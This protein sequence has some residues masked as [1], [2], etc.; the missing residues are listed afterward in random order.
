MSKN[1]KRFFITSAFFASLFLININA[2][3]IAKTVLTN[4]PKEELEEKYYLKNVS[5]IDGR[6]A[7]SSVSDL[8][9]KLDFLREIDGI[10]L[11]DQLYPFYEEGFSPLV[12]FYEETD[13]FRLQAYFE[14]KNARLA[15]ANKF[16]SKTK[17]LNLAS[18][19]YAE[20]I[21]DTDELINDDIF[22]GLLNTGREIEVAGD[23]YKFTKDGIY[24]VARKNTDVMYRQLEKKSELSTA[25][26]LSSCNNYY[27]T[28]NNEN[29]YEQF[30][31]YEMNDGL[32]FYEECD[33]IG[34]G[35]G[36]GSGSGNNDTG[37]GTGNNDSSPTTP[38]WQT[39]LNSQEYCTNG[40]G[41][42]FGHNNVCI[43]KFNN[44]Y[45]IKTLRF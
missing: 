8:L 25:R 20:E 14:N 41:D 18:S 24:K 39:Y 23:V 44:N 22:A 26:L 43:S 5:L 1:K 17:E 2:V 32:V 40:V 31:S 27:S 7:F 11:S 6:L 10:S 29:T 15:S 38:A 30:N 33:G 37:G 19:I 34:S 16:S 36:S 35:S 21:D 28:Q 9:N 3:T 42:I 13:Q 12:P 4:I 45:R